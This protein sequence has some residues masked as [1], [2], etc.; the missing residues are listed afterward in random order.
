[1]PHGVSGHID[2]VI[3]VGSDAIPNII[4][5]KSQLLSPLLHPTTI[6]FDYDYI[7]CSST[8]VAIKIRISVSGHKDIATAV[9]GGVERKIPSTRSKL[10][11]SLLDSAATVFGYKEIP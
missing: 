11:N 6:E 9:I 2:I 3:A 8:V 7:L 4:I 10:L 5:G 1:M